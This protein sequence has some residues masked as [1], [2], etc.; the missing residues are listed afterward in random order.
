MDKGAYSNFEYSNASQ[1]KHKDLSNLVEFTVGISM[2][3]F[4]NFGIINNIASSML[5]AVN[6]M[7]ILQI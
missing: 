3:I 7:L 2:D 6:V 5:N 1:L 4:F